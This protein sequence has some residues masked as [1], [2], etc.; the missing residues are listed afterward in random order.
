GGNLDTMATPATIGDAKATSY[1]STGDVTE[2]LS[3][4]TIAAE[5]YFDS[6]LGYGPNITAN[7]QIYSLGKLRSDVWPAEFHSSPY[8]PIFFLGLSSQPCFPGISWGRSAP[9]HGG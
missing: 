7:S 6:T 4:S 2:N 5:L 1:G 8:L 3:H 9:S